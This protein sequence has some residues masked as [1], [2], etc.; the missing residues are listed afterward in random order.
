MSTIPS[1]DTGQTFNKRQ[2]GALDMVI[3]LAAFTI[4]AAMWLA[5]AVAILTN[6]SNIDGTW[7]NLL[8]LPLLGKGLLAFLFLPVVAGMWIW[9][10]SWHYI[11]SL[12]GVAGLAWFTIYAFSHLRADQRASS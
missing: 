6:P 4:F 9:E 2:K 12:A 11:T 7:K 8:D 10:T 1:P 3:A 5:F